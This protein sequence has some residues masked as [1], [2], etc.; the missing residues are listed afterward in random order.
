MVAE[1]CFHG[2]HRLQ[3]RRRWEN[4]LHLWMLNCS[5]IA[6]GCGW[7][8]GKS[9]WPHLI[10]I[11]SNTCCLGQARSQLP[12][13]TNHICLSLPCT[14]ISEYVNDL[15]GL[16]VFQEIRKGPRMILFLELIDRLKDRVAPW[17]I[18][19]LPFNKRKIF[20]GKDSSFFL[21]SL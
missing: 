5:H 14:S 6:R 21:S 3:I 20:T 19:Y 12:E 13:R 8:E 11:Y 1:A 15:G 18:S 17:L 4:R 2:D 10:T 7:R 9:L 16:L